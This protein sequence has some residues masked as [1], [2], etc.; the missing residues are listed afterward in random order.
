VL[1]WNFIYFLLYDYFSVNS[2]IILLISVNVLCG[3]HW[4]TLIGLQIN[5][6]GIRSKLI[7]T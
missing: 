3:R 5:N 4:N 7:I 1:L 6:S 2:G